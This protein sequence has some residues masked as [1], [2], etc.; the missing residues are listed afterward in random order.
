MAGT[1]GVAEGELT[2]FP[3]LLIWFRLQ[4]PVQAAGENHPKDLHTSDADPH[5]TDD[6]QMLLNEV[7]QL[8]N[9]TVLF[10]DVG[11]MVPSAT[12]VS[13]RLTAAVWDF[14][15]TGLG[16]P[17]PHAV[18]P[19]RVVVAPTA[20]ELL[21]QFVHCVGNALFSLLAVLLGHGV[22]QVL[23]QLHTQLLVV[24]IRQDSSNDLQEK[25]AQQQYEVHSEQIPT[26]FEGGAA[27][28]DAGNH[29]NHPC[30][31]QNISCC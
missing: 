16:G 22:L 30:H 17:D 29:H 18:S 2:E 19:V 11:R 25:D 14:P 5:R 12:Q 6:F 7:F 28:K 1:K 4:T 26:L 23:L 27:A 9:T 21:L 3:Q 13:Y 8:G 31:H 24:D 15:S 10:V 20:L